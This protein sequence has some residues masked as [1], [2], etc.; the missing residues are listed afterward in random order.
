MECLVYRKR[1]IW[2]GRDPTQVLNMEYL[3]TYAAQETPSKASRPPPNRIDHQS[4]AAEGMADSKKKPWTAA[5]DDALLREVRRRGPR[6]WGAVAAAALPE[7]GAKSCRLRWCQHLDPELDSRSFT[8]EEDARIVE[9]QRVHGNK[10]ATIARYLRG[11]SDNAVKNR[12]NS[13][14]RRMQQGGAVRN[15]AEAEDAHADD[16]QPPP[17]LELFPLGAGGL[18][19]AVASSHLG[20]GDEEGDAASTRLTLG[21][22]RWSE[23]E[24]ATLRLGPLRP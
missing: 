17:C 18:R 7:R 11:R 23:A 14:L 10:W 19:N 3:C 6:N 2:N 12:W 8:A 21:L 5:E 15:R 1:K 20:V 16:Q 4:M 24:L 22:E 9:Q 13:A